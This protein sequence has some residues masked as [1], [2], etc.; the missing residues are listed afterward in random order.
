[1]TKSPRKNVPD[2]GNKTLVYSQK[3]GDI[4]MVK[5]L[6][7]ALLN[8]K[9]VNMKLLWPFLALNQ[10]P[11]H[12]MELQDNAEVK[13]W[14]LSPATSLLSP[15]PWRPGLKMTGALIFRFYGPSRL[16]HSFW[17]ESIVRWGNTGRSP[18]KN[19]WPPASTEFDLSSMWPKPGSNPQ[20]WNNEGIR[21]LKRGPPLR[22]KKRFQHFNLV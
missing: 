15:A 10:K 17:A 13:T 4:F 1:M 6:S 8:S 3:R 9:Q 7:K 2:V 16:F 14:H 18:R 22:N 12:S 5:T 20:Q 11:H 21:V 19:T